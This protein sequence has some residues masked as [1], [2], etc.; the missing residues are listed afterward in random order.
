LD[1]GRGKGEP[2]GEYKREE[3]IAV[4]GVQITGGNLEIQGRNNFV[5]FLG[6][7]TAADGS[8]TLGAP[9]AKR[10]I[11]HPRI[12]Q[13]G[14]VHCPD[15]L[16]HELNKQR[17]QRTATEV[18]VT[19]NPLRLR[20]EVKVAP[21]RSLEVSFPDPQLDGEDLSELGNAESPASESR[22]EYNVSLPWGKVDVLVVFL[23][24][25]VARLVIIHERRVRLL[26]SGLLPAR[27]PAFALLAPT[28]VVLHALA[29]KETA[30]DR[31]YLLDELREMMVRLD[32]RLLE[33]RHETVQLV[34]D[35]DGSQAVDPRLTQDGNR[36]SEG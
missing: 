36:L 35:E 1:D 8:S 27:E 22:G 34:D 9:A 30:R 24:K 18:L 29:G 23:L 19:D 28:E 12:Q 33:F 13:N 3:T 11:K 2:L 17:L 14:V 31:V 20:V 26:R 10:K 15:V 32:R 16:E 4:L 5:D 6:I 21:E 7:S 25:V